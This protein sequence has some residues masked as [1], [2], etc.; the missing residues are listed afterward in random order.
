M[1]FVLHFFK[2]C[3]LLQKKLL[4]ILKKKKIPN[5]CFKRY[6]FTSLT[7]LDF[8]NFVI[9]LKIQFLFPKRL[10]GFFC[11]TTLPTST[12]AR[13]QIIDLSDL[14]ERSNCNACFHMCYSLMKLVTFFLGSIAQFFTQIYV[15]CFVSS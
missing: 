14:S 9:V 5:T 7:F 12:T 13:D 8:K 4:F 1:V 3:F 2:I 10:F 6:L 15:N 11:Q